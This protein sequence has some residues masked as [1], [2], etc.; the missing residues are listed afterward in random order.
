MYACDNHQLGK[1]QLPNIA[2]GPAGAA[3]ILVTMRVGEDGVLHVT[4]VDQQ[5]GGCCSHS[6]CCGNL[7]SAVLSSALYLCTIFVTAAITH[8]LGKARSGTVRLAV[9]LVLLL[10]RKGLHL[11]VMCASAQCY[12]VLG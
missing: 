7:T 10:T 4:A 1:F 11:L 2:L 3:S 8:Q 6:C 12:T 5:S 9:T